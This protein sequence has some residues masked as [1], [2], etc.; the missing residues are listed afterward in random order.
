MSD[1]TIL[2][3]VIAGR[4]QLVRL[5]GQGGMGAVYEGRN[6]A[7]HKRCAVKL[8]LSPEFGGNQELVKRFFREAKASSIIES[9]HIVQV[10]DSGYDPE[11]GWPFMVMEMLHGEDLEGT[12]KRNGALPPLAAAKLVLQAAMGLAKAHEAG[13]VHRDIKPANLF[14]S[15]RETGD[16]I[17]KLLDFG[18]AKVRMENIQETSH[19]LTRTGSMLGTPLYMSPEQVNGASN[20]DAR[21]DVWSLGIVLFELLSGNIPWS[22]AP[23]LGRLMASIITEELP[24][25]QDRAPWVPPELAEVTHRAIS[26][27][28]NQRFKNAGELRD[29]LLQIVPDGARIP[30]DIIQPLPVEHKGYIAPRLALS[31]DGML[32]ATTRTGLTANAQTVRLPKKSS[33]GMLVGAIGV[34]VIVAG[35]AVG[36]R[37]L[38]AK[39]AEPPV[40]PEHAVAPPPALAPPPPVEAPA[41]VIKRFT[42]PVAP[43]GVQAT[44][45]GAVAAVHDG[46]ID[47]EGAIGATHKIALTLKGKTE[48]Y[49]VAITEA[50]VVPPKL[51]LLVKPDA[52]PPAAVRPANAHAVTV[53]GADAKPPEVKAK[54]DTGLNRNTDEFGK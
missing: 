26:R 6:I 42:L 31:G 15:A 47:V 10:Y 36:Y 34:V 24:L 16:L 45:D 7:T 23:S 39:P 32:R 2:G 22:N 1:D 54:K 40:H 51:D 44:L 8:L 17:V 50:G 14:L 28:L 48:E 46:S 35:G 37:W 12:L 9:D 43:L 19:G 20:I 38:N 33:G 25:L 3:K 41:P 30:P 21:S 53:K 13:I 5:L 18:I 11:L 4:Y 52:K 27:D 49:L 29:A